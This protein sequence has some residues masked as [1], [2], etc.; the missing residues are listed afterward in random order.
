MVV[1]HDI[2]CDTGASLNTRYNCCMVVPLGVNHF[3]NKQKFQVRCAFKIAQAIDASE[4]ST[5]SISA[6]TNELRI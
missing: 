3:K 1:T 2:I 6:V 4:K 5:H